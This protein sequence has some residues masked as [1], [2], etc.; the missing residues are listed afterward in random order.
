MPFLKSRKGN[1]KSVFGIYYYLTQSRQNKNR[2]IASDFINLD[3]KDNWWKVMDQTRIDNDNNRYK[4]GKG[5]KART[6]NHYIISPD[7]KDEVD[8]DTLRILATDWAN[9]YFKDLEVAIIYHDDNKNKIPHAHIVVNNTDLNTGN[10]FEIPDGMPEKMKRSLQEIAKDLDLRYFDNNK[11]NKISSLH[12]EE[13]ATGFDIQSINNELAGSV[14]HSQLEAQSFDPFTIQQ[15]YLTYAE[16]HAEQNGNLLWKEDIRARC[17]IAYRTTNSPEEFIKA[18]EALD[19]KVSRTKSGKDYLFIHPERDSWNVTGNRLG[20]K[21]TPQEIK[22]HYISKHRNK[23]CTFTT[24]THE[25]SSHP[26][27]HSVL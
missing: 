7:P 19:L 11:N 15:E 6:Y 8:L 26:K 22:K 27:R 9:K 18:C 2:V 16:R 14:Q 24:I 1:S 17:D 25:T 13:K 20:Y 4:G 21:Y 12:S 3:P 10:R 23:E 5:N